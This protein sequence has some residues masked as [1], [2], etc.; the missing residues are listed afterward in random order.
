M[1]SQRKYV[2][3]KLC[4]TVPPDG[5]G[6][7]QVALLPTPEAGEVLEPI[8]TAVADAPDADALELLAR[9]LITFRQLAELGKKLSN[10]LLPGQIGERFKDLLNRHGETDGVRLR[11]LIASDSLRQW[12]WEFAYLNLLGKEDAMRNFLV[13]DPRVSVVRHEALAR[14]HPSIASNGDKLSEI[15][16]VA[17]GASPKGRNELDIAQ[18]ISNLQKAVANFDVEGVRVRCDPV[19]TEVTPRE[20]EDALRGAGSVF[21]FHFAG[22][23]ITVAER[24][25]FSPGT[26][27]RGYL[28]LLRDKATKEEEG[29]P[30][31]KLAGLLRQAG[32]RLAVL[33]A[34]RSGQRNAR[35][36]W[37]GIAGA[38]VASDV[39][40]V[41][42]MQYEVLDP[43][44]IAFSDAL[45]TALAGGVSL[46]EAVW[47][48]RQAML[49]VVDPD[50]RYNVEWGVPV[51][52]S[53]L[54]EGV[55][56]P[57]RASATGAVA[58]RIRATITQTIGTIKAGGEVTGIRAKRIG[59]EVE[60][61]QTADVVSGS[62]TGVKAGS[63]DANASVKQR[64]GT[65]EQGNLTG[66]EVDEF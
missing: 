33:S 52:Y 9:K 62:V 7:C 58:E 15:R 61:T 64:V 10:C 16:I 59:R 39:P 54:A 40:V 41:L 25:E 14:P 28:L 63:V 24:A 26:M 53:R 20:L 46:D 27:E 8:V 12:P 21:V 66:I 19:L 23:G 11:L 2:D 57:E 13:L 65:F 37:D 17:A 45:Y 6:A 29:W 5:Q 35:Y 49:G 51:L 50:N 34:C 32:V 3:F 4:L 31:Q 48:G 18:E 1:K 30:A 56:F 44:A 47:W 36:P 22:H 55:L 60:V 38:L 42:A 43:Q